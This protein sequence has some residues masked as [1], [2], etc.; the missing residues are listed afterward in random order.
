M[1]QV[2]AHTANC[3]QVP[4]ELC[5]RIGT[6]ST[7]RR[8]RTTRALERAK[9]NLITNSMLKHRKLNL[10]TFAVN[11]DKQNRQELEKRIIIIYILLFIHSGKLNRLLVQYICNTIL[12]M[13]DRST[14]LSSKARALRG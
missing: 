5:I 10:Q 3:N 11:Q 13:V 4:I 6:V 8:N 2:K 1:I 9:I 12:G 14:S 7:H